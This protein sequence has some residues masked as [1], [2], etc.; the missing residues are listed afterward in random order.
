MKWE[1]YLEDQKTKINCHE[2]LLRSLTFVA[3][4]STPV[5]VASTL[6]RLVTE[7]IFASWIR[8]TL[9][10]SCAFVAVATLTDTWSFARSMQTSVGAER[11]FAILTAP[12]WLAHFL[13]L[14]AA[15]VVA[16]EVVARLAQ[17]R[18]RW[19]VVVLITY[20]T[21]FIPNASIAARL[22]TII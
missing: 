14:T 9:V 16:E 21:N 2:N 17:H 12:S 22:I 7:A 1:N 20:H 5:L 4:D 13:T 11:L 10:A 6:P 18:A 15:G 19:V 3:E 8:L